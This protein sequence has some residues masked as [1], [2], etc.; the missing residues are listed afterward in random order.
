LNAGIRFE[1][2]D[3][4]KYYSRYTGKIGGISLAAGTPYL[5]DFQKFLTALVLR[6]G[7]EVHVFIKSLPTIFPLLI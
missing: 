1:V 3:F 4:R 7:E 2:S 6:I 5:T